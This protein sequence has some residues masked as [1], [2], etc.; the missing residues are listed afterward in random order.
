MTESKANEEV[1]ANLTKLFNNRQC[2]RPWQLIVED[3]N[4]KISF[5]PSVAPFAD[6]KSFEAWQTDIQTLIGARTLSLLIS[7]IPQPQKKSRVVH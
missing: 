7:E 6:S 4:V 1:K 3:S 5:Q 2:S